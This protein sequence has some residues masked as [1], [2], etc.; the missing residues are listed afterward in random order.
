MV[1]CWP[2]GL[3]DGV[4]VR[5]PGDGVPIRVPLVVVLARWVARGG[6]VPGGAASAVRV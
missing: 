1:W 2:Q 5:V 3:E 4:P 6:R